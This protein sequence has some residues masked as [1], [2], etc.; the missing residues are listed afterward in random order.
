MN[1]NREKTKLGQI[2][3]STARYAALIVLV[4]VMII[5]FS[6]LS[7]SFLSFS[8][9]MNITRQTAITLAVSI[10]MTFV[11]LTGGIDLSV[12]SN[13]A[14]S[15]M[16]GIVILNATGNTFI[17]IITTLLV[18]T[19]FG[20]V[21]GFFIGKL[22][23]TAFIVTLAMQFFGRG[24]TMLLNGAAS[25]KVSN[26]LYKFVGQGDIAGIPFSLILITVL[27][28]IFCYIN[29]RTVFGRKVYAIGGNATA[30]RASGIRVERYTMLIYV[31]AGFICGIGALLT[32]GRMGSAQPY[33]GQELEFNCITA[34]VLGGTSL[35]GGKGNLKGTV[36][37]AI[38]VGIINNGLGLLSLDNYFIYLCTGGLILFA[39]GSD[40]II[41]HIT[42]KRLVPRLS[43]EEMMKESEAGEMISIDEV[44]NAKERTVEMR[45]ITKTYPGMKALDNVSFTIKPGEIHALM[46]ENGAGKSTLMR[47]LS[48][49]ETATSG[50]IYINGK[51]AA[52][53]NPI[54][55]K[56]MGISLIHQEIALIPELTV[57]QNIYLGKEAKAKFPLFIS[58]RKMIHDAQQVFDRLGLSID[59][60]KK[61]SSLTVSE[62]QMVEIIKSLE[63]NAWLIIMDEPTSSLTE[64]EKER[65][66]DMIEVLK[67]EGVSVVYISHRMQEIFQICEGITVL[68]DGK[69]VGV[70]NIGN[71]SEEKIISMMVGRE[72]SNIYSYDH[73]E[74]GEPVI[75][76]KN[77]CKRGVFHDISF[78]VHKHEVLGFGGLIGSGRTEVA[79]C[80]CGLDQPDSGEIYIDGKKVHIDSVATAL[81]HGIAYVP[82]DRKQEGFV[83]FMSICENI[84]MSSF[85]KISK[86]GTINKASEKKL[87]NHYIDA[88]EIKTTSMKKNVVE[89]SGGNQQKVSL[90]NRL[91]TEPKILILDEPTRGIDIG[92]KAEIHQLIAELAK[93]GVAVI[94]ISSEM[95]ELIGCADNVIVLR[96]GTMSASLGHDELDQNTIMSCAVQKINM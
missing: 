26:P 31:I 77:L 50:G 90:A 59:V 56:A 75:E 63:S 85:G 89:L 24:A 82:E 35:E 12:G 15:G 34:V 32:V 48:G 23:I 3:E 17:A 62:Q 14:V 28:V 25:I 21:N 70:E 4:V 92:A 88:L 67:K 71:V 54:D 91:S 69:C 76:V 33:A 45:N 52:I 93:K 36:L 95:P 80:I 72:L 19:L 94:L 39:V 2:F 1:N 58:K 20:Y 16:L 37:G 73:T 38:L 55:A 64:M 40:M 5:T 84:E 22:K 49:E 66:F 29:D 57:A 41:T 6:C 61:V 10:G 44:L 81:K 86:A 7:P 65:L 53:N 83:P 27:Y 87:A 47:I 8:N 96:E 13:I 78:K 9:L 79:R 60:R 42:N 68:R 74:L 43:A 51:R 46:G 11:I 18:A 30:A